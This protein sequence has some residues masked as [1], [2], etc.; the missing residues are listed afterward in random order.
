MHACNLLQVNLIKWSRFTSD[1]RLEKK[2]KE[3]NWIPY[4]LAIL[5]VLTVSTLLVLTVSTLYFL[6]DFY[7]QGATTNTNNQHYT[8]TSQLHS[9]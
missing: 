7:W 3:F 6:T 8:V 5:L 9:T 2:L 1:S 4:L